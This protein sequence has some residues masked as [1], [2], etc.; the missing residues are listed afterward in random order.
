MGILSGVIGVG[1]VYLFFYVF[2]L[3][4]SII[5][6]YCVGSVGWLSLFTSFAGLPPIFGAILKMIRILVVRDSLVFM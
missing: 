1:L 5:C 6:I 2:M 3:C 4:F